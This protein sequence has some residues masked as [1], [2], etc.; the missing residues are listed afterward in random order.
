MQ[1]IN[2]PIDS[3]VWYEQNNKIHD[4]IQVTRIANS[5]KEFWWTQP[6]VIDNEGVVIIGHGRLAWAKQLWLT[7]VPTITMNKLTENQIRKLRILD[8]KLNESEWHLENLKF[9]MNELPNL[10]IWDIELDMETLFPEFD[11]PEY[12]PDDYLNDQWNEGQSTSEKTTIIITFKTRDDA[13]LFT[14]EIEANGYTDYKV[15][16]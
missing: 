12:N 7:E 1:I 3:I 4:D 15:V 6:I 8:N 13:D 10:N 9:E 16:N 14:S 5:I 11:A 2:S